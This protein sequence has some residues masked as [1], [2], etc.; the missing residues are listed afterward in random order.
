MIDLIREVQAISHLGLT[1]SKSDYDEERDQQLQQISE[2]MLHLITNEPVK[3]V[4]R[5]FS[6]SKEYIALMVD[7]KAVVF[8]EK[9]EILFVKEKE[10]G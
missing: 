2:Q 1:Y 5:Y 4:S 7:I 6:R 10:Y 8:N 3:L 9:S